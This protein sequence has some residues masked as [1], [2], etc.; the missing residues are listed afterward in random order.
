MKKRHLDLT[1]SEAHVLK[2]IKAY[3]DGV[4]TL[5]DIADATGMGLS[6]VHRYAQL[7]R[8]KGRLEERVLVVRR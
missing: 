4:P 2:A 7:L 1:P 6:T 5:A 8:A 3:T